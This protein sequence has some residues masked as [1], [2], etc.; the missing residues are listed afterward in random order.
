MEIKLRFLNK[1]QGEDRGFFK[2]FGLGSV[3]CFPGPGTTV[4][5]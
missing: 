5:I 1:T 3:K 2:M 4:Y